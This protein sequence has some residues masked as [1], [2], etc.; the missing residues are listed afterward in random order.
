MSGLFTSKRADGVAEWRLVYDHVV[1]NVK[2]G[3]TIPHEVLDTLLDAK[4]DRAKVYRV[5]AQAN[6]K[7]HKSGQ[8]SLR[9]IRTV[10]YRVLRPEEHETQANEYQ[11]QARRRVGTA[12]SIM[13]AVDLT[14]MTP[15]ARNWALQV[16]AGLVLMGRAIDDHAGRLA[17]HEDLIAQLQ[18]RIETLERPDGGG[19]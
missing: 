12:I 8:R 10:G 1:N 14:D 16:T 11:A 17:R 2:P 5:V 6:R 4:E 3:D 13:Q 15:Q 9:V 7:L 18:A 19:E